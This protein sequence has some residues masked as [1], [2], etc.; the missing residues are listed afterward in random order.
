VKQFSAPAGIEAGLNRHRPAIGAGIRVDQFAT[1]TLGAMAPVCAVPAST[2]SRR[3]QYWMVNGTVKEADASRVDPRICYDFTY[4]PDRPVGWERTKTFGHSH[5]RPAPGRIGLAEIIEVL[6]GTIG[7]IIAD[8]LPGPRST[9]AAL[10]TG[11]P[12][13]TIILPPQ[14]SHASTQLGGGTAVFSDVIDR[15]MITG[16]LPAD[17]SQVRAA[18]GM[19]WYI[20]VDGNGRPNPNYLDVGPLQRFS[21]EE[22]SGPAS[23]RPLYQDYVE[24]PELFDWITDPQ[25]FPERYPMLW[26]RVVGVV[27][28]LDKA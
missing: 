24:H 10:V 26:E 4:L 27:A 7:F 1:R 28:G 15:R 13:D 9:F 19:A 23:D 21:A 11:K 14:L 18:K 2:S 20:D 6:Q 5:P 17:Y 8:L 16:V 22:W 3:I 12:G 25:L